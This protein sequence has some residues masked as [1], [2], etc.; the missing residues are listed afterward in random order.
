LLVASASL[1]PQV[2]QLARPQE[3]ARL[4]FIANTALRDN[5]RWKFSLNETKK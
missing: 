3:I 2:A 1:A 5:L 4:P